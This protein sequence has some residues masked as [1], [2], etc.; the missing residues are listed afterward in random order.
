MLSGG[1]VDD[2]IRA[3][4]LP[5]GKAKLGDDDSHADPGINHTLKESVGE[6]VVSV[7]VDKR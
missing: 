7:C 5:A 1:F 2:R 6:I 3:S 4:T